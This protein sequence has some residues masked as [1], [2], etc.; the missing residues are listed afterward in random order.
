MTLVA[1]LAL[2][3]ALPLLIDMDMDKDMDVDVDVGMDMDMDIAID[4]DDNDDDGTEP[5]VIDPAI[6]MDVDVEQD[7]T[8]TVFKVASVVSMVMVFEPELPYTGTRPGGRLEADMEGTDMI[9]AS[10][11]EGC[12][13]EEGAEEVEPEPDALPLTIVPV[14]L[15]IP[16]FPSASSAKCP[17]TTGLAL[18]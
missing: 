10:E 7:D 3:L 4:D 12:C 11:D 15:S 6:D 9:G 1:A 5:A 2:P 18:K 14:R 17:P 16:T 8:V 13:G